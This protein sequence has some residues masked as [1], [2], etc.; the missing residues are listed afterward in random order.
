MKAIYQQLLAL[1][2]PEY[3]K[4]TAALLPGQENILGVRLPALRKIAQQIAKGD[5]RAFLARQKK[6]CFEEV[7][8]R[9]MVIGYA[10]AELEEI[11]NQIE[12]FLPDIDNWSVCDSFCSG[13]KIT[14]SHP[15]EMWEFVIAHLG[16]EEEFTVRFAVVMLLWYY[17]KPPYIAAVLKNLKKVS[18]PG[19]YAKMS[20]AWALSI[21]YISFPQHTLPLLEKQAFETEVHN[22]AIQKIIESHRI[23]AET[24]K[25]LKTL[26]RNA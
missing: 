20:V 14:K 6:G 13:L 1:A 11:R 2:E 17:V 15:D 12:I 18:H 16:A 21:C 3:Q 24:K 9:G 10:K 8:L 22:K 23:D 19:Y 26:K 25:M 5:W 4:F 7:M